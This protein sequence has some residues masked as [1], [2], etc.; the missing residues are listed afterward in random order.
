MLNETR[1]DQMAEGEAAFAM[2]V[3]YS[4]SPRGRKPH[5]AIKIFD[6]SGKRRYDV[7]Y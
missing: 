4:S 5:L 7:P 3:M 6:Q 1:G 2:V